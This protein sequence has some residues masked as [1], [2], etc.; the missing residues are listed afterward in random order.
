MLKRLIDQWSENLK[1]IA[2]KNVGIG[3]LSQG[4][5]DLMPTVL[6]T[7]NGFKVIRTEYGP[8][9]YCETCNIPVAF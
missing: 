4:E 3:T 8:D 7:P 6:S 5:G 2:C 9:F 1:C